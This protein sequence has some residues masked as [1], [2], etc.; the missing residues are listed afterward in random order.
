MF[1]AGKQVSLFRGG[2]SCYKHG[3]ITADIADYLRPAAAIERQRDSL[4]RTDSRFDHQQIRTRRAHRAQQFGDLCNFIVTAEVIVGQRVARARLDRTE[5]PEIPAD[6]GLRGLKA[7]L[8]E[9]INDRLL[10]LRRARSQHRADRVSP[11][12]L[13]FQ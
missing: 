11:R 7:L 8:L 4:R 9:R 6:T 12:G 13:Y 1:E 2:R 5:F 10:G 3:V